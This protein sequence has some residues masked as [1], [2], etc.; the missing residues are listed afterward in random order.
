MKNRKIRLIT[1]M[2]T[3]CLT[4]SLSACGIK[5]KGEESSQLDEAKQT[6][7]VEEAKETEKSDNEKK[8][9]DINL[10]TA[11]DDLFSMEDTLHIEDAE[12][13]EVSYHIPK[14]NLDMPGAKEINQY[15]EED[16]QDTI[17][18]AEKVPDYPE[19]RAVSWE[20]NLNG[21]VLSLIIKKESSM[22]DYQKT[23]VYNL[24]VAS[25]NQLTNEE[26]LKVAAISEDEFL[27]KLRKAATI[28]VDKGIYDFFYEDS[29]YDEMD[30][31]AKQRIFAEFLS[32]RRDTIADSNINLELP[33]YLDENGKLVTVTEI[34]VLAGGGTYEKGL[35]LTD[36]SSAKDFQL[37]YRDSMYIE[38]TQGILTIRIEKNEWS[39]AIFG[40]SNIEFGKI[41]PVHGAIKDYIEGCIVDGANDEYGYPAFLSDDGLVAM[42]DPYLCADGGYFCINEPIPNISGVKSLTNN[43]ETN[44]AVR[45]AL[46]IAIPEY[47]SNIM[48]MYNGDGM[49]YEAQMSDKNGDL[50]HSYYMGFNMENPWEFDYQDSIYEKEIYNCYVGSCKYVGMDDKGAVFHY[51]L[52]NQEDSKD[53][54]QGLFYARRRGNWDKETEIWSDWVDFLNIGGNPLF[55][56]SSAVIQLGLSQG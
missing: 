7:I 44:D 52:T 24:D 53:E 15:I 22:T 38:Y 37:S 13:I 46:E 29:Y 54:K 16:F 31:E 43:A 18:I 2:S 5:N 33:M 35:Y 55:D 3:V 36:E 28:E 40:D 30:I 27:K 41:Y 32:L 25:G 23:S 6:D 48:G 19:W 49:S 17:K 21:E 56:G 4:L 51:Q 11:I 26:L 45:A 42:I 50:L 10:E 8:T 47:P 1:F 20:A 9:S 34:G 39:D 12:D 14:I